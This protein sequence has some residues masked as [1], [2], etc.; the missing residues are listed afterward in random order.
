MG[1]ATLRD[2]RPV[3]AVHVADNSSAVFNRIG[4]LPSPDRKRRHIPA[5]LSTHL[6]RVFGRSLEVSEAWVG[7]TTP[8][9]AWE[10]PRV[11]IIGR[12][13]SEVRA[14][15]T[16][17]AG[18]PAIEMLKERMHQALYICSTV[19]IPSRWRP[20]LRVRAVRSQS[21]RREVRTFSGVASITRTPIFLS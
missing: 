15:S 5:F 3:A 21:R 20:S 1:R 4:V 8:W 12:A 9:R 19:L 14:H 7:P 6:R 11:E 16:G 17:P 13:S 2:V 10:S 18:Q